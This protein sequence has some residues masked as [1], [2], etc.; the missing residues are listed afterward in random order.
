MN[1]LLTRSAL[2]ALLVATL[3]FAWAD[4]PTEKPAAGEPTPVTNPA[5]WLQRAAEAYDQKD[6]AA[7]E[8]ACQELVT[9]RP[10][11][12][13]YAYLLAKSYALQEKRR[14]AY[15]RLIRMA[16]EGLSYDLDVDADMASLRGFEVYDYIQGEFEKNAKP[17]G[18]LATV[19]TIK[20]RD[21]LLSALAWDEKNQ[22][23]LVGSLREGSV[24]RVA[25]DGSLTPVVKASDLIGGVMDIAVDQSRRV[26][27]VSAAGVPQR[28]GIAQGDLGRTGVYQF[29]L[30]SGELIKK[31][32][33]VPD[34]KPHLLTRMS[35]APNGD[36]Y[37]VD[38]MLPLVYRITQAQPQLSLYI[39][40][41]GFNSLRDLLVDPS[42]RQMFVADYEQ[43]LLR[44][45]LADNKVFQFGKAS[46]LNL[47]GIDGLAWYKDS[48]VAIQT[49]NEPV[50]VMRMA[51]D[52]TGTQIAFGQPMLAAQSAFQDPRVIATVGSEL[53]MLPVNEQRLYD[54]ASGK[55]LASDQLQDPVIMKT[56]LD[57]G[58]QPLQRKQG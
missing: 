51:L 47:G 39:G 23:W 49:G 6:F 31:H 16:Q 7:V 25:A 17:V 54:P 37:V 57:A 44:V 2:A 9:L 21:G 5:I 4:E 34:G 15:D 55:L 35:L 46:K 41:P 24:S 29:N 14:E 22:G 28:E 30:D 50:K 36:L 42:G 58:W 1:H 12:G 33:L 52:P 48:L 26:L 3:S 56:D 10:Y 27:W 45:D 11:V 18:E 40:L 43:G 38:S 53:F 32:L 13:E 8:A 20:Q 19:A